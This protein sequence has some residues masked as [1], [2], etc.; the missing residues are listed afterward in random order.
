MA[1]L[2]Q[3]IM[4][5]AGEPSGDLLGARLMAALRRASP[6]DLDFIGVGGTRMA[7]EGLRSILPMSDLSVMGLAEVVPRIPRLLGHIRRTA[8]FAHR[9]R[10]VAIVTIDSPGFN[11]RLAKRLRGSGIPIIHYVAPTVWAWRPGRARTIA[12]LFEH[13]L[14]LLPFEPPYFEAVG[15]DCTF[16]GHPVVEQRMEEG[17]GAAFRARHGI[18]ADARLLA[19]LPGSRHSETSRLLGPFGGAARTIADQVPDLRIV[20]PTLPHLADEVSSAAREWPGRPIVSVEEAEKLSAFQASDAALAA[21]GT[22]S[23]ELALA[24]VPMLVAYRVSALTLLIAK[25][26]VRTEHVNLINLILG[27]RVI[28]EILHGDCTPQ[29]LAAE[30]LRLLNDEG[31]GA[32]QMAASRDAMAALGAGGEPPSDRAARAVLDVMARHPLG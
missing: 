27:R 2:K 30:T 18:A 28:P 4:L 26:L 22:V 25:R 1:A 16:V 32:E 9:E 6:Q 15:L 14:A 20:V 21:S 3:S 7:A 10:P 12:P 5:V 24:G 17:G 8:A 13:L 11:F 31:A 19:V 23:L 29:R